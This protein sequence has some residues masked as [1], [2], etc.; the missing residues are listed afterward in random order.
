MKT[1]SERTGKEIQ[2]EAKHIGLLV[3][4]NLWQHDKWLVL[5]NGGEFTVDYS[6]GIGLRKPKNHAQ[7]KQEFNRIT[8]RK[9]KKNKVNLIEV[10]KKIEKES[11]PVAP[12]LDDVLYSLVMDA[13]A[14]TMSFSEWCS[15]FEYDE[16]SRK[17]LSIY[18]ACRK[19]ADILRKIGFTNFEK[20]LDQF[21]DY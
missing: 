14:D 17:A 12:K 11:V 8:S 6:T 20:L 7:A 1:K 18:D 5:F 10:N 19:N 16:D 2:F 15:C 3:D 9:W 13:E 21:C 4:D